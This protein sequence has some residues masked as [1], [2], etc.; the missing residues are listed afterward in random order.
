MVYGY[1]EEVVVEEVWCYIALEVAL[2]SRGNGV[3]LCAPYVKLTKPG[4]PVTI[5]L[6]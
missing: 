3:T 4:D 1:I 5:R 2:S 6:L